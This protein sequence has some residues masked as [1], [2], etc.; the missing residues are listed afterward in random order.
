[1]PTL[2]RQRH[3]PIIRRARKLPRMQRQW[4][5]RHLLRVRRNRART[6]ATNHTHRPANAPLPPRQA[7]P[8]QR[9]HPHCRPH[10]Q[11]T[12]RPHRRRHHGAGTGQSLK[13]PIHTIT[14]KERFGLITVAGQPHTI[15]DIGMRM[16]AARELYRAQGFPDSY[17]IDIQHNGKPLTKTAQVRMAGNSVVPHLSAALVRSN[18]CQPAKRALRTPGPRTPPGGRPR[19]QIVIAH[20]STLS[21]PQ[22]A[23]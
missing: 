16:L 4:R 14:A 17:Q 12:A 2:S 15:T 13:E 3:R 21:T 1:M 19:P 23:S 10:G 18:Y 7:Q 11:L 6:P 8:H 5:L 9:L 20:I 22:Q